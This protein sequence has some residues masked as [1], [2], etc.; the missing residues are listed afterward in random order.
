MRSLTWHEVV[1]LHENLICEEFGC[2]H[3][4]VRGV[5]LEPSELLG[6]CIVH[7]SFRCTFYCNTFI[8]SSKRTSGSKTCHVAVELDQVC[9][10]LLHLIP[11]QQSEDDEQQCGVE[12]P[13]R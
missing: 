4:R 1:P 11:D 2:V 5:V 9:W 8:G 13:P 10:R 7:V 6:D 3:W 12:H